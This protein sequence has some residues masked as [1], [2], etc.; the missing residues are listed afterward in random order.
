MSM[1][2][3]K[4]R[5]W[6]RLVKNKF[7]DAWCAFLRKNV[8]YYGCLPDEAQVE[9]Q[10][11]IQI[12]LDEKWF[13]G[14]AGLII[15][16]EIRV[17]IAA[18][19]CILLLHRKTENYPKL[20]TIIVYPNAYLVEHIKRMPAGVEIEAKDVRHGE[21]WAHGT[22]VLSWDDVL[23]GAEQPGD[24]E[25]LVFHEFAHQLDHEDG[26][27]NGAPY[28]PKRSMYATWAEVLGREYG[29]LISAI[30]RNRKTMLRSYGATN[31]AE[32]FAVITELFFE[33]PVELKRNH[34]DLYTQLQLFFEQDPAKWVG[35]CSD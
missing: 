4:Q 16:D 12:F 2:I 33:Q 15:T 1:S 3:F 32:F 14:A 21:S 34:P 5:R 8:P 20:R 18:Q 28:L 13:E 7:P 11:L 9:L 27:T 23:Q 17:T 29:D 19:A 35:R 26:A 30:S 24:G 25:N 6:K 10:G 31:P 22:I